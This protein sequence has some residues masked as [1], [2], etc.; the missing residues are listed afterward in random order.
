MTTV[1]IRRGNGL[2]SKTITMN[3]LTSLV[4]KSLTSSQGL[5]TLRFKYPDTI[6]HVKK[7]PVNPAAIGITTLPMPEYIPGIIVDN[8]DIIDENIL[9]VQHEEKNCKASDIFTGD[10]LRYIEKPTV[11]NAAA[12][13]PPATINHGANALAV[14]GK[15]EQNTMKNFFN[16]LIE[17]YYITFWHNVI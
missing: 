11:P 8:D 5:S 14:N 2:T 16:R 10:T 15:N 1:L 4:P 13:T 9:H 7:I 3:N 12:P 17:F 6:F